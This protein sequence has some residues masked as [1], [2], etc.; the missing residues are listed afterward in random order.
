[1]IGEVNGELRENNIKEVALGS[2][3]VIALYSS[4]DQRMAPGV[5]AEDIIQG[6]VEY[7]G[8]D[9]QIAGIFLA[10]VWTRTRQVKEGIAEGEDGPD[11]YE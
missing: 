7:R 8:M 4:I 11:I 5:G 9:V 3:D 2:M 1:M 10:T 6:E